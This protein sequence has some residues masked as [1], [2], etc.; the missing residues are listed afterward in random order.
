MKPIIALT[1][2]F[3]SP[4]PR[5]SRCLYCGLALTDVVERDLHLSD[6]YFFLGHRWLWE[7]GIGALLNS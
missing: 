7:R 2:L 3:F 1:N 6:D 4:V 5:G